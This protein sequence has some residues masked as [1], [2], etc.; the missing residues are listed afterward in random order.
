[1]L[2]SSHPK[3]SQRRRAA[4][5]RSP[6]PPSPPSRPRDGRFDTSVVQGGQR[7]QPAPE[8]AA[9]KSP[10]RPAWGADSRRSR[11]S[12][13]PTALVPGDPQRAGDLQK[14]ARRSPATP[15]R[16]PESGVESKTA[17]SRQ[18]RRSPAG[19][20]AQRNRQPREKRTRR[21]TSPLVHLVRLLILGVGV[22]AIAGTILSV[23]NPATHPAS[24]A[25]TQR[26]S[27]VT[28]GSLPGGNEPIH[29]T[30]A[31]LL[32]KGQD[33]TGLTPKVASLTQGIKDLTPGMFL[34]DLDTG[35]SFS[36][37][38][39]SS[40]AS[41]SMIKVP[42]LIALLQ[43]V[44]SGR[45]RLTEK[46]V[47]QQ[48]DVAEGS[49]DLQYSPIGSDYTVLEVIT[50]MITISDNT[51]TNMIIRRLGGIESLNQRFRQ[52]GL[53]QTAIR[54]LLPD[55]EG[56]NTTSPKELSML[57]ARV[58]QGELLSMK[59]RDRALEIMRHTVTDT[60][61]PT[62]LREGGTISHKTG[63]IG[64]LVGDTGVIDMPNDKRYAITIMV[65]RP[66]NDDRAQD[67]IRQLAAAVYDY[68]DQT[69][70]GRAAAPTGTQ[71]APTGTQ[72]G[73]ETQLG[74]GT[75]PAEGTANHPDGGAAN[76]VP[77]AASPD[78]ASPSVDSSASP[79][80]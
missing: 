4:R 15:G 78:A 49:G 58:S 36:L 24:S 76:S 80:P 12:N 39:D 19:E 79:T 44:D 26:A 54:H 2:E 47:M 9:R 43:D 5:R 63:D 62:S 11:S 70:G 53:Q 51:A 52:W 6:A 23:W 27:S 72:S 46:M 7:S 18:S 1:M 14:S 40:F 10:R 55:L 48:T 13:N 34:M 32:A 69:A 8:A 61:L 66:N 75:Q 71:S 37:N 57:M 28:L 56:T 41:A 35:D 31:A 22:G 3:E 68:M 20:A 25:T 17:G 21:P 73:T 77:D 38:G 29:A 74:T 16:L 33:L 30:A 60:L 50:Y 64:S 42:I 45:V 65:K 67:L 59:S